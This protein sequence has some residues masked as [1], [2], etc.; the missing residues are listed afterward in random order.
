MPYL[1]KE[2][3]DMKGIEKQM[4][5][6]MMRLVCQGEVWIADEITIL[7]EKEFGEDFL[8]FRDRMWNF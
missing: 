4:I 5:G 3:D 2:T 8:E 6:R 7:M 1:H